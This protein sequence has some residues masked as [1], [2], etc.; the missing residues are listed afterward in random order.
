MKEEAV[1][2]ES[3]RLKLEGL[4]CRP[5]HAAGERV[6][7]VC[8]PHPLY[9]GSMFDVIV[10]AI[11]KAMWSLDFATLRFNF[12]GVGNS[13]GEYDEGHGEALDAEAA[14]RF[15][16]SLRGMQRDRAILAGYSF[17]AVAA[18]SA[19][20]PMPEVATVV[21]VAPPILSEGLV[22]LTGLKKRVVVIAGEE[23]RYC[24]PSQVEGLRNALLGLAR[25]KVIAGADHFFAGHED[26]VT[27]ALVETL[28]GA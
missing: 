12:R 9:G 13:Q 18:V 15:A 21:A 23:D 11:L 5:G 14:M 3:H 19:A 16:T 25:V 2:F 7:V 6:A 26:Q 8:H 22:Q 4:L 28:R 10:E 27:E 17:G 20:G 24:P 1:R